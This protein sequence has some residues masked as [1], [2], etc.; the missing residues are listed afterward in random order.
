MYSKHV[1]E[2]IF[3]LISKSKMLST[4][5]VK[6]NGCIRV[7]GFE[8]MPMDSGY[9]VID[10]AKDKVIAET[11]TKAAALAYVRVHISQR[12]EH[13]PKIKELDQT[14]EKHEMDS[15]FYRHSLTHESNEQSHLSITT[16]LELAEAIAAHAKAQI[17][18]IILE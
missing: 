15:K 1:V 8:I 16:R 14:V 2:Q 4:I 11:W 18:D 13:I 6:M 3:S 10:T 12:H 5:P 7:G 17:K 9:Y